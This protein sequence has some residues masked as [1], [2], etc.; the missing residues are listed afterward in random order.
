MHLKKELPSLILIILPVLYLWYVWSG[1][2][3]QV[4]IHWNIHGKVDRYGSKTE[5]F[6]LVLFLPL[7][8]YMVFLLVPKIDPKGLI[9][10]MGGKYK[11]LRTILTFFISAIMLMIIYSSAHPDLFKS[12][13][14]LIAVS[15]LFVFLGNYFKTVR[16]NYFVGI[17]TPWTLEN[18]EIWKET[19]QLAGKLWFFGGLLLLL[20][21]MALPEEIGMRAFMVI[22]MMLFLIP[23]VYSFVLF[24]RIKAREGQE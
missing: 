6:Y 11:Q 2:P 18:E 21:T 10:R 12:S 9:G 13:F 15:L 20:T 19:H 7:F 17:R 1:L 23:V 24:R 22:A 14:I 4:P 8:I 3:E 16:P 5:L